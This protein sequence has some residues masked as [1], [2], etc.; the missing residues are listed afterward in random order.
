[1]Y[2]YA[3]G[4]AAAISLAQRVLQGGPSEVEAYLGFLK[5]GGVRY[6]LDTLRAAGV[7]ME[8]PEPIEQVVELFGRR[9]QE[10]RKLLLS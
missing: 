1:V 7:D 4:I 9:V 3:T 8:T 10:L 2:K 6:P 5:S